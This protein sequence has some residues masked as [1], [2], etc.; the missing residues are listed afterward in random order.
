MDQKTRI[1]KLVEE[2]KLTAEEALVLIEAIDQKNTTN[3]VSSNSTSDRQSTEEK[4]KPQDET[5]SAKSF[6]DY[7]VKEVTEV[8]QQAFDFMKT[9]VDQ[10]KEYE[11]SQVEKGREVARHETVYPRGT[12][13]RLSF[14]VERGNVTI[15][16]SD[17]ENIGLSLVATTK[18]ALT[19]EAAEQNFDR[20]V[21][22][23][24]KDETLYVY[25]QWKEADVEIVLDI[26]KDTYDR[27]HIGTKRG[28]VTVRHATVRHLDIETKAGTIIVDT[29][30]FTDA[31]LRTKSGKIEMKGSIGRTLEAETLNGAIYVDSSI[32]DVDLES[33]SGRVTFTGTNTLRKLEI[34]SPLQPIEV[35]VPKTLT[36]KGK[37]ETKFGRID[38]R[39]ERPEYIESDNELLQKE[40][41]FGQEGMTE[42]AELDLESALGSILVAHTLQ[43]S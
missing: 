20:Y 42:K 21:Q 14:D 17:R 22:A 11:T 12:I 32:E 6:F 34:E 43:Q 18:E 19:N 41:K 3:E 15:T 7:M 2:N 39:L 28:N 23:T 27:F 37:A 31:V 33:K 30:D 4:Q 13:E 40:V 8:G 26:P 5:Q 36:L 35:Y 10:V 29:F 38:I 25:S 16:S 9:A 1:L 24:S